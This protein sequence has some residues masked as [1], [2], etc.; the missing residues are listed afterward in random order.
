[1][2]GQM[3]V[4][5]I[6]GKSIIAIL[7]CT[8]IAFLI[9]LLALLIPETSEMTTTSIEVQSYRLMLEKF[10]MQNQRYPTNEEGLKLVCKG[11][12]E[13]I[14]AATSMYIFVSN[15]DSYLIKRLGNS[16]WEA[17]EDESPR[18]KFEIFSSQ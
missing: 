12:P 5:A 14:K 11:D 16:W 15:S 1:M 3:T 9:F 17:N 18:L 2:S 4:N 10:K 6:V 8:T 13:C 7:T